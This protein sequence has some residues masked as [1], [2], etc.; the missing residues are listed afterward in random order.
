M[1]WRVTSLERDVCFEK[2]SVATSRL[3]PNSLQRF[4]PRLFA[5]VLNLSDTLSYDIPPST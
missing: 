1:L 2:N 4:H 3:Q 5:P